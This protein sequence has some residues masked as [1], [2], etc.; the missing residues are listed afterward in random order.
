MLVPD[1][2]GQFDCEDN[3]GFVTTD[4]YEFLD[5]CGIEFVWDVRLTKR[6][7]F[8]LYT[9]LQQ[10]NDLANDGDLDALYDHIQS[11]TLVMVNASEDDLEEFVEE[12]VV[13]SEMKDIMKGIEGLLKEKN[14]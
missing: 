3:C 2:K 7:S 8:D 1:E 12:A 10:I 14:D 5:H 11:A 6:L 4:I 13:K 9:F